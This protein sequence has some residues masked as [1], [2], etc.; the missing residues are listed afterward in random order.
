MIQD[1]CIDNLK[2]ADA[3]ISVEEFF[4]ISDAVV[5]VRTFFRHTTFVH[6]FIVIFILKRVSSCILTIK[7]PFPYGCSV[8][9]LFRFDPLVFDKNSK[10]FKV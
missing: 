9:S 5:R 6:R 7:N 8:L 4:G 1:S 2:S 10:L 3:R